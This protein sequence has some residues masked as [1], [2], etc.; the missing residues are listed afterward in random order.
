MVFIGVKY[1]VVYF[2]GMYLFGWFVIL[3]KYM[4]NLYYFFG[5]CSGYY[6]W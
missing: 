4:V 5:I 3:M 6:M 2:G 1:G